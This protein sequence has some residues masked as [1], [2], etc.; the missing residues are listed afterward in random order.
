MPG[1]PK[2][3]LAFSILLLKKIICFIVSQIYNI[4][5]EHYVLESIMIIDDTL[6]ADEYYVGDSGMPVRK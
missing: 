4:Y 6:G 2:G 5:L 1:S 3:C